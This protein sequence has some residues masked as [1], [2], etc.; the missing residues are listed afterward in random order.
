[1]T[2]NDFASI[3]GELLL[4]DFEPLHER[5]LELVVRELTDGERERAAD[6]G[7]RD[8]STAVRM[9]IGDAE[10]TALI[11]VGVGALT[12][13]EARRYVACS[14][15]L[16][17]IRLGLPFDPKGRSELA[18]EAHGAAEIVEIIRRTP[19]GAPS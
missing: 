1:M 6:L 10:A 14:L 15:A 19:N 2:E 12:E 16:L 8:G 4:R 18:I 13:A 7:A 5:E 17:E 9:R 3:V 11:D